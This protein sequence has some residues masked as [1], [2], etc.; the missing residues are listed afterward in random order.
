MDFA[1]SLS[2]AFA[3]FSYCTW[4]SSTA[5]DVSMTLAKL[6]VLVSG[7]VGTVTVDAGLDTVAGGKMKTGKERG[8]NCRKALSE[9]FLFF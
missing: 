5:D 4:C 7:V 2:L 9:H 6:Y 1:H 3:L 8:L